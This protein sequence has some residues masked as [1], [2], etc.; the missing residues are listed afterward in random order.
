MDKYDVTSIDDVP[1]IA[2]FIQ[3]HGTFLFAYSKDEET[4]YIVSISSKFGHIGPMPWSVDSTE[5]ILVSILGHGAFWFKLGAQLCSTDVSKKL[6]IPVDYSQI[7]CEL[8][9]ELAKY[10]EGTTLGVQ[11]KILPLNT[12]RI[13]KFSSVAK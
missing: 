10:L 1:I 2:R 3:R 13:E 9:N 7:I 4:A 8:L 6:H 11:E 5:R 12:L